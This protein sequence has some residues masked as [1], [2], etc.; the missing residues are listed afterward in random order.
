VRARTGPRDYQQRQEKEHFYDKATLHYRIDRL[1]ELD[2]KDLGS[3]DDRK[4]ESEDP[5]GY[6]KNQCQPTQELKDGQHGGRYIW[7]RDVVARE[8][9]Y[10]LVKRSTRHNAEFAEAVYEEYNANN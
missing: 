1:R 3:H 6:P 2:D 10:S 9:V 7:E 8:V 4:E 5:G